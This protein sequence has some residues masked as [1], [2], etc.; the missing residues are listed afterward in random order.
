MP[1]F[2]AP[3]DPRD[4]ALLDPDVGLHHAEEGVD[5]HH[6]GDQHVQFTV[7]GGPVELRL[8]G[9]EVLR[10]APHRL[11]AAADVVVLDPDPGALVCLL[12]L[13]AEDAGLG[14]ACG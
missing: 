13:V 6:A 9:T 14:S 10:V 7:R 3:A 4:P 12:V 11:V 5:H 2:P 8:A 1:G